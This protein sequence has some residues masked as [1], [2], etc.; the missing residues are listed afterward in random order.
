M[1]VVSVRPRQKHHFPQLDFSIQYART[2]VTRN[3]ES[4]PLAQRLPILVHH[5]LLGGTVS[6]PSV[7]HLVSCMVCHC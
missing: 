5:L 2:K 1:I 4:I 3:P 7:L 6:D